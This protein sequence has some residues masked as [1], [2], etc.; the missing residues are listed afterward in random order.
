VHLN[1]EN[2]KN[3]YYYA[4][5]TYGGGFADNGLSQLNEL[6]LKTHG[7]KLNYGQKIKM[8]SNYVIKYDMEKDISKI[9]ESS[10]EA[11]LK[12]ISDIGNGKSLPVRKSNALLNAVNRN[13]LKKAPN[14]AKDYTV[15][16][17]C[18]GCGICA[19]VCPADNVALAD[20]KPLFR[21]VCEQCMACIQYCPQRAINYKNKTQNRGRYTHPEIGHAELLGYR[22]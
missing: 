21:A 8:F 17:N 4:I 7:V 11:L 3:A 1:V 20:G 6:L 16:G 14:M 22:G 12:A 2:N 10:E 18:T 13:F 5:V 9:L 19:E 15:D